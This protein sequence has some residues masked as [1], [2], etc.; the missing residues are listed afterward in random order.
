M[1]RPVSAEG[2]TNSVADPGVGLLAAAVRSTSP[3][4]LLLVHSGPLP[5]L[6]PGATR[7]VLDVRELPAA[8]DPADTVCIPASLDWRP[9]ASL[10]RRRRVAAGPPR[11]GLQR[12]L[13]GPRR[14]RPATRR[15]A[16]VRRPQGQGRAVSG[17]RD[18]RAVRRRRG[19]SPR[20]RLLPLH[21]RKDSSLRR[22]GRARPPRRPLRDRR[23][24]AGSDPAAR[25]PRRVLPQTPRR[26]HP[27]AARA[28]RGPMSSRTGRPAASSTSAPASAPS[29]C[30]PPAAGP[31][32]ASSPSTAT[33]S[34][35]PS[36]P[37]TPAASASPTASTC[38]PATASN[39]LSPRDAP[40]N[41]DGSS[42]S[43][44]STRRPTPSPRRSPALV[45]PLRA[46]LR[47][48]APAWFVVN[49]AGQ[50]TRS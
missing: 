34:P 9:R 24:A 25:R 2:L 47:P 29:P 16:A 48:G 10:R 36:S 49:R 5:G 12:G 17:P 22:R 41:G 18:D 8:G 46:W 14:A 31:T 38:S 4:D 50:L 42:T 40:R 43:P 7:L 19:H 27:R 39:R 11:Q 23:P 28:P 26:R 30:G 20:L 21:V 15:P 45:A 6:R 37:R 3:Q 32:P 1:P 13:P 35:R 33:C 44:S